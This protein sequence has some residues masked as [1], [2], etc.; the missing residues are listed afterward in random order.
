MF[1]T[2]IVVVPARADEP[3][4]NADAEAKGAEAAAKEEAK[5]FELTG[6]FESGRAKEVV[7]AVKQA[8]DLEI[9]K[10]LSHG[11]KVNKGES[12]VWLKTEGIDQQ[13]K[14]AETKYRLAELDMDQTQFDYDQFVKTQRLDDEEAK[15]TWDAAQEAYDS[16]LE[17][18]RD[19][20]IE[21][22]KFNLESA[23]FQ[24]EYALEDLR[25]LKRMYEEDELTEESEELV[26]KRA[27]RD[28]ESTK[29]R[30][31]NT[32][33]RT[34][35]TLDQELPREKARQEAAHERARMAFDK[36]RE[37]AKIAREKRDIELNDARKKLETQKEELEEL[38]ADRKNHVLTAAI[39]GIV[40]HGAVKRGQLGDKPSE[41]DEGSKVTKDQVLATILDPGHLQIRV[42]LAEKDFG[43]VY[44]GQSCVVVPTAFSDQQLK[45]KVESVSSLPVS[46]GQ[47]DCVIVL[48]DKQPEGIMPGMSCT[49]KLEGKETSTSAK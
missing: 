17:F 20:A 11:S 24:L 6:V 26:L 34:Q 28:V 39:D 36:A 21:S 38:R 23:N 19:Y 35:R 25:Q 8:T 29:F 13:L 41:L 27:E 37:A 22:A 14:D 15:R 3:A 7:V 46:K 31:K 42:A 4:P 32:E 12:V 5:K 18:E 43:N 44:V 16:Y 40:Y 49:L 33:Y 48:E 1:L 2:L 47:F 30:L 45:A 9:K 10:I